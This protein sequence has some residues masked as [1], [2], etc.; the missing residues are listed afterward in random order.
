MAVLVA[1]IGWVV[2]GDAPGGSLGSAVA[3]VAI[4]CVAVLVINLVAAPARL[5][6]EQQAERSAFAERVDRLD[7]AR[8][9]MTPRLVFH[10]ESW[11][12][13]V[14]MFTR[15]L[16]APSAPWLEGQ[17]VK[18]SETPHVIG[19]YVANHPPGRRP[20]SICKHALIE[21]LFFYQG[22]VESVLPPLAGRWTG[23]T[24][25]ITRDLGVS[26]DDLR[27]RDLLPTGEQNAIDIALYYPATDELFAAG[28]GIWHKQARDPEMKL[29]PTAVY[30][31]QATIVGTGLEHPAIARYRLRR[32][33]DPKEP[34][35]LTRVRD[36]DLV[37]R[38]SVSRPT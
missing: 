19:I 37:A 15:V 23:N 5:A 28:H 7:R 4:L 31:V 38:R 22:Q 20:E 30:E 35:E 14:T 13:K 6:A 36:G 34:L 21:L 8:A 11:G 18:V 12:G 17:P 25:S 3:A 10:D 29:D 26:D 1:V 16:A 2:G 32:T 27:R 33:D 24:Q 9:Q